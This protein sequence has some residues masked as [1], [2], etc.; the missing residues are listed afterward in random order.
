MCRFL[1]SS[2]LSA[3]SA[4]PGRRDRLVGWAIAVRST[5]PRKQLVSA[6]CLGMDLLRRGF[7]WMVRF[8]V[9]RAAFADWLGRLRRISYARRG[10]V[11][12]D[13]D[14]S[15]VHF[16]R[17]RNRA[18]ALDDSQLR[19]YCRSRHSA[20]LLASCFHIP[21]AFCD[22][23]SSYRLALLGPQRTR[24]RGVPALRADAFADDSASQLG[25]QFPIAFLV[26]SPVAV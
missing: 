5:I 6:S 10:L 26:R 20:H 25:R 18:P 8:A 24:R 2:A 23:L 1:R 14:R 16:T 3:F 4:R 22:C 15:T 12:D 13:G 7:A 21:L 11:R 19:P 17:R 9:D